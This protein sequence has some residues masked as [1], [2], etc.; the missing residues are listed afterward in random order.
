MFSEITL[1]SDDLLEL[2]TAITN[3]C[4][5]VDTENDYLMIGVERTRKIWEDSGFGRR[6]TLEECVY[7]A[8]GIRNRYNIPFENQT[9]WGNLVYDIIGG[10]E[11]NKSSI[12]GLIN[13]GLIGI[14]AFIGYKIISRKK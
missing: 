9:Y 1:P 5:V 12:L 3:G 7:V 6:L 10:E 4:C 13:V 2:R 11:T 14:F 8:D